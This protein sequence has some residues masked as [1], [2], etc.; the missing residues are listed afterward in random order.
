MEPEGE[1]RRGRVAGATRE[2]VVALAT[3]WYL[4]RRRVDVRALAAELG[5]GRATVYRW[6]GAREALLGEV[7]RRQAEAIFERADR[8]AAAAGLTGAERLLDVFDRANRA[9]AGSDV[10]RH[11]IE[12]EQE[13]ALR[14]LTDGTGPVQPHMVGVVAELIEREAAS[15]AYDPPTDATTLGYAVVR[16]AEAFLYSDAI[17][18]MRGDM[19]RLRAIEAALLGIRP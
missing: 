11:F 2:E 17:A 5:V 1:Q 8:R 14:L 13:T 19:D 4:E 9:L 16:L 18:G 6:F 7:V 10:L 12:T 15:G 3:A